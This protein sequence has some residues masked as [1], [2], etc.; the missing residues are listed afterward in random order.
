MINVAQHHD[1]DGVPETALWTL[2]HRSL[3]ARQGVLDDPKA[4][5]LVEPLD[6]PFAERFGGG[7]TAT[8]QGLR[9][10]AF[11]NE[12]RRFLKAQA[13][14]DRGRARR[15]A[16]DPVLARGQR[17]RALGHGRPAGVGR[18]APARPAGR[19]DDRR[20]GAGHRRLGRHAARPD[21]RPGPADVPRPATRSTASS[22]AC[23]PRRSLFDVVAPW[24]ATAPPEARRL[25]GPAVDLERRQRELAALPV[26]DLRRV[27]ASRT[28]RS[29]VVVPLA[30]RIVRGDRRLQGADDRR[31]QLDHDDARD[32]EHRRQRDERGQRAPASHA[33]R[34]AATRSAPRSAA[35]AR[36]RAA[37]AR[38]SMPAPYC[39]RSASHTRSRQRAAI[40]R[41][42]RRLRTA[43]RG[44]VSS[45]CLPVRERFAGFGQGGHR[46]SRI[47]SRRDLMARDWYDLFVLGDHDAAAP[48]AARARARGEAPRL[49]PP[50][51]REHAQDARG[52]AGRGPG[53]A[54]RGRPRRG[55]PGSASR[56]R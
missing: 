5:E 10:R 40:S 27:A 20:L 7:E 53:D 12:I 38:P 42:S 19:R 24:L 2:Y 3:A 35:A 34:P 51:A 50:P 33:A 37:A 49:L 48:R 1:A 36:R 47:S 16:R 43:R 46:A 32:H 8:W 56:R 14:R 25:R 21:H 28:A 45:R 39:T 15:R 22:S 29:A 6:Y 41:A 23:R 30:T 17:P 11:D 18:A 31:E 26:R 44:S 13:R 52:A 4:I 55:R 9:V 54:V